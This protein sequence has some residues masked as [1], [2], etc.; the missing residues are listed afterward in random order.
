M[1]GEKIARGALEK[2]VATAHEAIGIYKRDLD[3]AIEQAE[4]ADAKVDALVGAIKDVLRLC[5]ACESPLDTIEQI[6]ARLKPTVLDL[7]APAPVMSEPKQ[8]T[9][10]FN[11]AMQEARTEANTS[12]E[13]DE[14]GTHDWCVVFLATM[15]KLGRVTVIR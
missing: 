7:T 11:E 4:R 12:P 2:Q 1:T 9:M 8:P 3:I 10:A 13:G 15:E 6:V 5:A 14:P